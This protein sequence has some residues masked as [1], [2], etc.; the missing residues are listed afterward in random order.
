MGKEEKIAK[1]D[2]SYEHPVTYDIIHPN[3][4]LIAN[5]LEGNISQKG[6]G[7]ASG[8]HLSCKRASVLKK[9]IS[10]KDKLFALLQLTALTGEPVACCFMLDD[11][12][13][14]PLFEAGI[15]TIA[16]VIEDVSD[17]MFFEN[18]FSPG[19]AYLRGLTCLF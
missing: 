16:P 11:F 5:K 6:N 12:V 19:K 18:N 4:C 8:T 7:Y 17:P 3:H 14:N 1:E 9:V 2:E 10:N 13:Q 15:G